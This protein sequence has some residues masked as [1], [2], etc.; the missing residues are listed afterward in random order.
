MH[1][2]D[3]EI[4]STVTAAI[5]RALELVLPNGVIVT[6]GVRRM[7]A[8]HAAVAALKTLDTLPKKLGRPS[9]ILK[10]RLIYRLYLA[11]VKDLNARRQAD[12]S[13]ADG[14][15]AWLRRWW[16]GRAYRKLVHLPT[17]PPSDD[18][19]EGDLLALTLGHVEK[20]TAIE[21]PADDIKDWLKPM[22]RA[23]AVPDFARQLLSW[24]Y[25]LKD[26]EIRRAITRTRKLPTEKKRQSP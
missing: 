20:L 26:D 4:F 23:R 15:S 2:R 9:D 7:S 16:D 11:L 18:I 19:E 25:G 22:R 14:T 6:D 21:Y 13:Y 5:V 17:T 10:D 3:V 12:A 1:V 8:R 24:R